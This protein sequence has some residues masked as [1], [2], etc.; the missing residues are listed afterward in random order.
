MPPGPGPLDPSTGGVIRRDAGSDDEDSGTS[1]GGGSPISFCSRVSSP[2]GSAEDY[3]VGTY[4]VMPGDLTF[5]RQVERWSNDCSNLRLILEFSDGACPSGL[6]HS[7][8]FS[9]NYLAFVDGVIHGGNNF[10]GAD[11]ETPAI[12]V[13]YVRPNRLT[14][15]G[16][17]GTCET[18]EGQ[19]VFIEAPIPQPGNYLRARFQLSLTPCG[20]TTGEPIFFDGAFNVLMRTDA[21]EVCPSIGTGL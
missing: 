20:G 18:A 7:L 17:W 4:L 12:S 16:T 14:N 15:Y 19:L 1:P 3:P 5:T 6:G 21:T 8:T 13:R 11:A 9:F 2:G 10:V